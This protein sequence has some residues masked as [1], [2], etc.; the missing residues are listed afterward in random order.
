[1]SKSITREGHDSSGRIAVSP[2]EAARMAGFGRT[3]L[4]QALNSG[5][6][7]S[8]KIG[9]RRLIRI[10]ELDAWLRRLES[11]QTAAAAGGERDPVA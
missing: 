8:F 11:E 5:A 4:Y 6:L 7:P 9:S 2:S 3:K 1:M 10:S